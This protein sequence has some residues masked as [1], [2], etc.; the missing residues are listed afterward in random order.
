MATFGLKG[1]N[2]TSAADPSYLHPW[3]LSTGAALAPD[4]VLSAE[5]RAAGIDP[6][7]VRSRGYPAYED[8]DL[9]A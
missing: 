4:Q 1:K 9:T 2:L 8:C 3:L 6:A 7:H 5:V